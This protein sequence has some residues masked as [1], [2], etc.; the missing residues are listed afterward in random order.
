MVNVD[1]QDIGSIAEAERLMLAAAEALLRLQGDRPAVITESVL[2][3]AAQ[4]FDE[5][6]DPSTMIAY[7]YPTGSQPYHRTLGL[8]DYMQ[9]RL[10]AQIGRAEGDDG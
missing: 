8:L 7:A 10:H 6:G 4:T 9:T 5:V 2:V 1:A 3:Y